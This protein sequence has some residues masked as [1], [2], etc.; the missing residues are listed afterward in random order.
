MASTSKPDPRTQDSSYTV[1]N[2]SHLE[3]VF[4]PPADLAGKVARF[5]I[6]GRGA[7]PNS[8]VVTVDAVPAWVRETELYKSHVKA[9]EIT[10]HRAE[11]V[12]RPAALVEIPQ[13]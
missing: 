7:D 1:Q 13:V 2:H 6:A 8:P 5:S 12:S 9:R 4:D 10:N 11:T 3:L